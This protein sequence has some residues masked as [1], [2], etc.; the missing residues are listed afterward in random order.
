MSDAFD[1]FAD[2]SAAADRMLARSG[3]LKV[4]RIVDPPEARKIAAE[5]E[6]FEKRFSNFLAQTGEVPKLRE[7]AKAALAQFAR[8]RERFNLQSGGQVEASEK[9]FSTFL[10]N[11]EKIPEQRETAAEALL[12]FAS[13][14]SLLNGEVGN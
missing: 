7:D 10:A 8:A 5:I 2:L 13:A 1:G 3:E 9:K 11:S 12:K 6:V 4:L 14:K